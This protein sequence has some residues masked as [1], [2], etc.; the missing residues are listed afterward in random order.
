MTKS[1]Q[2]LE[3]LPANSTDVTHK[4]NIDRYAMQPKKLSS[5]CLA[6]YVAWVEV[7]Y[8]VK[9]NKKGEMRDRNE[10]Q[11]QCL[12]PEKNEEHENTENCTDDKE[13]HQSTDNCAADIFPISLWNGIRLLKCSKPKVI[14]FVNFCLQ[15]DKENYFR[16]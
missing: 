1:L 9:K 7:K 5:W 16:E 3:E 4:S 14:C 11:E 6:D 15:A 12:D 13:E 2:E 10:E 8:T